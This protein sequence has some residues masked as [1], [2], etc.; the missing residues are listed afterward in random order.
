MPAVI[1]RGEAARRENAILLEYLTSKVVLEE[2]EMGSTH[3][4]IKT[5]TNSADDE[6]HFV[7]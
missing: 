6:L 2:L 4:T 1:V 3:Q 7:M 5:E